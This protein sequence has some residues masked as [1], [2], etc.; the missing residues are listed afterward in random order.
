MIPYK[1]APAVNTPSAHESHFMGKIEE[2]F[3]KVIYERATSEKA[4]NLVFKEAED[5]FFAAC[6]GDLAPVGT[7]QGEFWGKLMLGACRIYSYTGNAGLKEFI[8]KS[9]HK[10]LSLQRE[11]GYLGTYKDEKQI[12]RVEPKIAREITGY[13]WDCDWTWNIWCRKYTIWA[14][15]EV[16]EL[17][18]DKTVLDAVV[19][20]TDQLI[21][22]LD[23]MGARIC[24]TG[25]FFGLPSGSI[26]KP[27]L[28]LYR[29]TE[30]SKYLDFALEIA[31]QWEDDETCCA[32]IIKNSLDMLP[33]HLWNDN[34]KNITPKSKYNPYKEEG[35]TVF[36][37]KTLYPELS[38]KVY[39]M[40]SCFD[41]LLELYRITGTE[42]YLRATKNFFE[43][44]VKYEYNTLFSVG[45]NDLFLKA[46]KYQNAI[47]ELCDVIHFIRLTTE[48]HSVTGDVKY[49]DFAEKAF[50]NPFLAG[51]SKNGETGARGVRA[52]DSHMYEKQVGCEYNHCC[53][54]NMPRGFVNFAQYISTSTESAVYINFFSPASVCVHPT[55]EEN[56]KI[57]VGGTY[58]ENCS[59]QIELDAKI[60]EPKKLMLR[61]PAWSKK[62]EMK[63]NGNSFYPESGKYFETT[64]S[65]GKTVIDICFDSTPQICEKPYNQMVYP[66]TPYMECRYFSP[67]DTVRDVLIDENKATLCIGP[68]L[69]ALSRDLK[70][71]KEEIFDRKTVFGKNAVCTAVKKNSDASLCEYDV[72]FTYP[73]GTAETLPMRDFASASDNPEHK[74][75]RYTIFI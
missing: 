44:I 29:I 5:A 52:A 64:L 14:L 70:S 26:M 71:S 41:G 53:T 75:Y 65:G 43:L 27:V 8:L 17:S 50:Y 32:K 73:D 61:V 54:N 63:I 22:M 37:P 38:Y 49:L 57:T 56:V 31:N 9:T 58:L 51:V 23:E 48:L 42:K 47:T 10:I 24:E 45:F 72:T 60:S 46:G 11:D 30:N 68:M 1:I 35:S 74:D 7:W 12:F 40:L 66:T 16:Y 2:K 59:A 69:L 33:V 19:R 3:Q 25:T 67:S 4:E 6:D 13:D 39:E 28:K 18:G 15:I 55:S 20:T 36:D 21:D 62:T 34:N